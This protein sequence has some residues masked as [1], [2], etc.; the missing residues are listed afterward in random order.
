M[1]PKPKAQTILP[2][3][4]AG[5]LA[6]PFQVSAAELGA[7][8]EPIK[9]AINEWTGQHVTTNIAGRLLE[10]LGYQVEYVTAGYVPQFSALSDG[11]LHASLENWDN[12]STEVRDKAMNDG[13]VV[14]IGELGL[15]TVEGWAYPKFMEQVCPGLPDWNALKDCAQALATAD[16]FP[17]GRILAYPADW[18][19]RSEMKIKGLELPYQAVPAGSEGALVAELKAAA[20]AE[21]PLI[22][23]FW[24]PHW[25]L[26]EVDVGWVELPAHTPECESDAAW[27]ANASEVHDC[28]FV[29]PTVQKTAWAGFAD[30]WPAAYVLLDNLQMDAAAQAQMMRSVDQLGEDLDTVVDT[31]VAENEAVWKPWVDAAQN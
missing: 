26:A 10:K 2:L 29:S 6:A 11:S 22:M 8:D 17:D 12:L 9:L 16:T 24:G 1:S 14:N 19:T 7:T 13:L 3:A 20:S 4:L 21:T 28:G 30:K 15:D 23:E 31:W 18:G 25:V 27:G 5:I